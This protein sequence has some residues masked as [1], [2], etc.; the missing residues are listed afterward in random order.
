M[1]STTEIVIEITKKIENKETDRDSDL[2]RD[3]HNEDL[4]IDLIKEETIDMAIEIRK[5]IE[6]TEEMIEKDQIETEENKA[7]STDRN[8]FYYFRRF[9]F[10]SPPKSD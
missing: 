5:M 4:E 6:I 8:L 2:N 9:R 10:D 7:D 3:K 1:I